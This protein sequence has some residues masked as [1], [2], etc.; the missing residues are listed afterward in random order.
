[1]APIEALL[2]ALN[3]PEPSGPDLRYDPEF[4]ELE[5]AVR[6]KPSEQYGDTVIPAQ[7]PEWP[8]VLG[9]AEQLLARTKD[10]RIALIWTRAAARTAGFDGFCQGVSLIEGLLTRLWPSVHP[11]LDATDNDDPTM[12]LN[13]L[14]GLADPEG[15]LADIRAAWLGARDGAHALRVRDLELAL[16]HVSP[17]AGDAVPS[18]AGVRAALGELVAQQAQLVK[19]CAAADASVAAIASTLDS[20]VGAVPAP[21]LQRLRDLT[22]LVAKATADAAPEPETAAGEGAAAAKSLPGRG[23]SAAGIKGRIESREDA[24]QALDSVCEWL[25]RTEPSNP[26]PLVIRRA[27][28]LM[29]M[30]F[31]EIVRDVA[32]GAVDQVLT[33]IGAEADQT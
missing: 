18:E 12:R 10:L 3:G 28:R 11:Q 20:N 9:A 21:D 1:L 32:P 30:N 13:A 25:A 2:T 4:M 14:A 5:K 8:E 7:E 31:L 24:L 17:S 19:Q 33:L 23:A 15:M 6:G 29:K 26:A 22:R 16:G 27:Q